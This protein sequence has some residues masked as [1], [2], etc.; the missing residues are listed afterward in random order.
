MNNTPISNCLACDSTSLE[1]YCDL[2]LQPPANNLKESEDEIDTLFPLAVNHC[3]H[4]HHSQ[5][6]FSV[7]RDILYKH[8][9][10][11]SG[12][13]QTLRDEF[14]I[15]AKMIT[16]EA[17]TEGRKILDI[18]CNDGTFLR[19]FRKFGWEAYGIDPAQNIIDTVN[20]KD[21]NVKCD[22]FPVDPFG[23]KFDAI[24]CFNVV[25][26]VPNPFDFLNGCKDLLAPDGKIYIQTSQREMVKNGEFD[27]IYHE[28][29][30]FFSISSMNALCERVGLVLEDVRERPVHG[31]SYLFVISNN[32]SEDK[33]VHI[34]NLIDL[35]NYISLESTYQNFT[36]KVTNNKQRLL[37]IINSSKLKVIGYGAAAKGVVMSNYIGK[38]INYIVDE[39]PLKI[40][41]VIGSV[42]IPIVGPDTLLEEPDDLTI[43]VYAWNFYDEVFKKIKRLRPN[44]ND[45]I[46]PSLVKDDG[47]TEI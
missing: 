44:N 39:N 18:A 1:L 45:V 7:D 17:S 4:C 12:T 47:H 23:I 31:K 38:K 22:Y 42:N 46:I 36:N 40:G 30:S 27:T 37:D 41:K 9:L 28:H 43:I 5:L 32:R 8:Y 34:N 24:T 6:T 25:A 20:D 13:T 26:H 3:K 29:H 16:D 2:G 19:S 11:V 35:E 33:N 10:Y 15:V 21:L 14:D